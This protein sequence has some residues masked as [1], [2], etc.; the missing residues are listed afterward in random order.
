MK[1]WYSCPLVIFCVLGVDLKMPSEK[2]TGEYK[3]EKAI[4][5]GDFWILSLWL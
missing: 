5:S 4:F 3:I 1:F 2:Q